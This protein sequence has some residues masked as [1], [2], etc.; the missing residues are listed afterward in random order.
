[1]TLDNM[2]EFDIGSSKIVGIACQNIGNENKIKV[3]HHCLV[4]SEG[5][6]SGVIIDSSKAEKSIANAIYAIE[7]SMQKEVKEVIL[8]LPGANIK[9][10]YLT[11]SVIIDNK[12]VSNYDMQK[13]LKGAYEHFNIDNYEIID[14]YPID[15]VINEIQ[16]VQN[17][18]GMA[19]TKLTSNIHIIAAETNIIAN[20]T[21]Y[22]A[23]Y[24][25]SIAKFIPNSIALGYSCLTKDEKT[26]GS[27]IIDF[28]AKTTSLGI[29]INSKP[30]YVASVALGGWHVTNDIATVFSCD[31]TTAEKLKVLYG[32]INL[33]NNIQDS[34]VDLE[35]I[36]QD[37]N[38]DSHNIIST[39][40]LAQVIKARIQEIIELIKKEYDKV[41]L[42]HLIHGK[43]VITGGAS[44]MR[45]IKEMTAIAF[46]KEVKLAKVDHVE[47]LASV[48]DVK[49]YYSALGA[50]YYY[51]SRLNEL[52]KLKKSTFVHKVMRWLKENI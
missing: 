20:L 17:P 5:I 52:S 7:K 45:G 40:T 29:F 3:T 41:E 32:Y 14:I 23:K 39:L 30:V 11:Y 9:S 28:G 15:F 33:S 37:N 8:S 16:N 10:F 46:R 36:S 12:T 34:L 27:I 47:G 4:Q 50:L 6:N 43:I 2:V 24:Q 48:V 13:L 35:E 49:L 26:R 19:A 51:G 38:V 31:L 21:N 44:S 18:I 1:M 42:N 22:F 25:I